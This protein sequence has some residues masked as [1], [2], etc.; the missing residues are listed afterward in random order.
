MITF[1]AICPHPPIIVPKIGHDEIN[2]C[3]PTV[4]AMQKLSQIFAAARPDEI[5]LVSP[6]AEWRPDTFGINSAPILSGSFLQFGFTNYH[7]RARNAQSSI[8]DRLSPLPLTPFN[9]PELDHGALVPLYY[10]SQARTIESLIEFSFCGLSLLEHQRFGVWLAQIAQ[11]S[12]KK[13][14]FIASGDL[15]HRLT[16]AAPAGFSPLG[17]EFDRQ[18]VERARANDLASLAQLD[19]QLIESAGECGLRSFCI[20]SGVLD[21]IPHRA[22]IFSYEGPFGVG[23][24]VANF[25]ING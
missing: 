17:A 2:R 13:V 1:A 12:K 14:A 8:P 25:K 15:S 21:K 10:L 5:W 23:Y 16:N 18:V 6:H 4:S 3:Q 22:E 9:Q 24:L 19:E 11:Q 7:F 20:L